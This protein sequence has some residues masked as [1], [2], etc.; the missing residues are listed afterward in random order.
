MLRARLVR[1]CEA[2]RLYSVLGGTIFV[3]PELA[4]LVFEGFFHEIFNGSRLM[5]VHV[6]MHG[7]LHLWFVQQSQALIRHVQLF[8]HEVIDGCHIDW[9]S[10]NWISQCIRFPCGVSAVRAGTSPARGALLPLF[11]EQ[12]HVVRVRHLTN[13]LLAEALIG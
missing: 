2:K 13:K 9:F 10:S 7:L 1:R 6:G 12:Q 4:L 3:S 11:D 8:A 5:L